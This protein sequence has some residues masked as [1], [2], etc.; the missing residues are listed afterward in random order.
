MSVW[1]CLFIEDEHQGDPVK[2]SPIPEDINDLK[3]AVKKK[4]E[5]TLRHCDAA[6]LSVYP[7]G[8]SVPIEQ[9]VHAYVGWDPVPK[10]DP[11]P[12]STKPH[13]LIVVAP[14]SKQVGKSSFVSLSC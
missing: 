3:E 4:F 14:A 10:M 5:L 8:T 13:I 1:V 11:S 7:D 2:I 6:Y 12:G 9:G